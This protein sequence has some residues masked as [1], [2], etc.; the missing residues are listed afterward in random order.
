MY[1]DLLFVCFWVN[2]TCAGGIFLAFPCCFFVGAF[3][4][5]QIIDI[6]PV[7]P[8]DMPRD[9]RVSKREKTIRR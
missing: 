9:M 4:P 6:K 8:H 3:F 7:I 2:L 1:V 5:V